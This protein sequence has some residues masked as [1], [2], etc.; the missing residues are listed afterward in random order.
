[1]SKRSRKIV[2]LALKDAEM[3]G[4]E[5]D[6]FSSLDSDLDPMFLPTS[7]EEILSSSD[8]SD[9]EAS[10]DMFSPKI[11]LSKPKANIKRKLQ[12]T[13][14]RDISR[15][16]PIGY[17]S[18]KRRILS[19]SMPR[20]KVKPSLQ[21][22]VP[23]T[24]E[25]KT[26]KNDKMQAE[27]CISSI[28]PS[29]KM[30]E[31]SSD[32]EDS[33][34]HMDDFV[35]DEEIERQL[36]EAD[37]LLQKDEDLKE[38][39]KN[40]MEDGHDEFVFNESYQYES[41]T[42]MERKNL[43]E[44]SREESQC[45]VSD[46]ESLEDNFMEQTFNFSNEAEIEKEE[47]KKLKKIVAKFVKQPESTTQKLT[48]TKGRSTRNLKSK[49]KFTRDILDLGTT[50]V[51]LISLYSTVELDS[52]RSQQ[53]E[54]DYDALLIMYSDSFRAIIKRIVGTDFITPPTAEEII[55]SNHM[56]ATARRW[57]RGLRTVYTV[58]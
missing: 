10:S 52:N 16:K 37:E 28:H 12:T 23:S 13:K 47:D 50:L 20:S 26:T 43:G 46:V 27:V 7:D 15:I 3:S 22:E 38:S 39:S 35:S 9:I 2:E 42:D 19:S 41:G 17:R 57:E 56:K 36:L 14:I 1:M 58:S 6:P 48:L 44:A 24:S 53:R 31:T 55:S 49:I 29:N 21:A 33:S 34:P 18:F 45:N 25:M 32:Q 51:D 11:A 30:E 4:D 40:Q 5:S 54:R 8:F